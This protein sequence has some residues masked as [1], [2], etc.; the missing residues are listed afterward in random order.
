MIRPDSE[1]RRRSIR[2]SRPVSDRSV[3]SDTFGHELI[4]NA[5]VLLGLF[6]ALVVGATVLGTL[7]GSS[8]AATILALVV[9]LAT[10]IGVPLAL[11]R[12]GRYLLAAGRQTAAVARDRR[13]T[14]RVA[15]EEADD[16]HDDPP[17]PGGR[18]ESHRS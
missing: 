9:I 4:A 2:N 3:G 8:T 1:F 6:A 12:I 13:R 10:A 7:G 11:A 5:L 18:I 15:P 14:P 17:A 16:G